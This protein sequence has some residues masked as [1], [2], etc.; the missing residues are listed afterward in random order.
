MCSPEAQSFFIYY[1][2]S[3][4]YKTSQQHKYPTW[5]TYCI[6]FKIVVLL[7]TGHISWTLKT[8][9]AGQC[10]PVLVGRFIPASVDKC[11]RTSVKSLWCSS[12]DSKV[13]SLGVST[14]MPLSG[15][16]DW[17]CWILQNCSIVTG[18]RSLSLGVRYYT[19][20]QR[21]FLLAAVL[22]CL[23]PGNKHGNIFSWGEKNRVFSETYHNLSPKGSLKNTL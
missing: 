12:L 18:A 9:F 2:Y 3:V 10:F 13:P 15:T 16:P 20:F 19:G 1:F 21:A 5:K 11:T 8:E 22:A 23:P 4:I 17:L 7:R 14:G 6:L